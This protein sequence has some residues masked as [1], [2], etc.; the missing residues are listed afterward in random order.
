MVAPTQKMSDDA[1]M[2]PQQA[3]SIP[4]SSYS[5]L[6][7]HAGPAALPPPSIPPVNGGPIS[8]APFNRNPQSLPPANNPYSTPTNL[9]AT[10]AFGSPPPSVAPLGTVQRPA[11]APPVRAPAPAPEPSVSASP[12]RSR[13]RSPKNRGRTRWGVVLVVLALDLG[14]AATGA[15]LLRA[16]LADTSHTETP[17]P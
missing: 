15:W 9:P 5:I 14:L 6:S 4:P 2:P 16:G 12:S 7:L 13:S 11:T 8:I 3:L 1:P 17:S 10:S